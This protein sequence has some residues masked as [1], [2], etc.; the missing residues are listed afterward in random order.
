[1]QQSSVQGVESRRAMALHTLKVMSVHS[2]IDT[3]L[4]ET[5]CLGHLRRNL[6]QERLKEEKSVEIERSNELLLERMRLIMKSKGDFSCYE[7]K[8]RA[9]SLNFRVRKARELEIQ[10]E[11][12]AIV[13]R[14]CASKST[15]A[16][17]DLL[18][19]HFK[20][21]F[22]PRLDLNRVGK[23]DD[24][25]TVLTER[26]SSRGTRQW[27]SLTDRSL[28]KGGKPPRRPPGESASKSARR[29]P[30][31]LLIAAAAA[32]NKEVLLSS[33]S[34]KKKQK[35]VVLVRE[36]LKYRGKYVVASV[37]EARVRNNKLWTVEFYVP[38]DAR[39]CA[40]NIAIDD[41][42]KWLG[43]DL[44]CLLPQ[45]TTRTQQHA[46]ER[47]LYLQALLRCYDLVANDDNAHY[48]LVLVHEAQEVFAM[49]R[50]V[51]MKAA[52][53]KFAGALASKAV[54][55]VTANKTKMNEDEKCQKK[56]ERL[57][58]ALRKLN[59]ACLVRYARATQDHLEGLIS[60]A[61][62]RRVLR[63]EGQLANSDLSDNDVASILNDVFAPKKETKDFFFNIADL[64]N[65]SSS[66]DDKKILSP[67]VEEETVTSDL[68]AVTSP[69]NS[70]PR[71]RMLHLSSSPRK[72]TAEATTGP[73]SPRK[74]SNDEGA[75][76]RVPPSKVVAPKAVPTLR[77]PTRPS[78]A[79][80]R[81]R[82]EPAVA[83]KLRV[84]VRRTWP[85]AADSSRE[86]AFLLDVR[87]DGLLSRNDF[88]KI[89][90]NVCKAEASLLT[91]AEIENIL[92]YFD[93]AKSG[94]VRVADIADFVV[95]AQ[96]HQDDSL[97]CITECT[98][99]ESPPRAEAPP[100]QASCLDHQERKHV[101]AEAP[102]PPFESPAPA[103]DDETW[104]L[105][106]R[107]T[108]E[109]DALPEGQRL[110]LVSVR[111][112]PQEPLQIHVTAVRPFLSL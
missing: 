20:S 3:R 54:C 70:P 52:L 94:R 41:A 39:T 19:S 16:K 4:P 102:P 81:R 101:V 6:K 24:A 85:G 89:I 86:L 92:R 14:L 2:E 51:A 36:A 83:E 43:I 79:S 71:R 31:T 22:L 108:L 62:L 97:S 57:M 103:P 107:R 10:A 72:K 73:R 77:V 90:R 106:A 58:A 33:S 27:G 59:E 95:A 29:P 82:L 37:K 46:K 64:L 78:V 84:L 80:P 76:Y 55:A 87:G 17:A 5:M 63:K 35:M 9:C 99:L 98:A 47:H 60:L 1:M 110:G 21:H 104:P 18:P 53:A 96:Q 69:P 38:E 100:Q 66:D 67:V 91:D 49:M 12:K 23:N 30:R 111:L 26:K 11:N 32:T 93:A 48:E 65:W 61:S 75:P 112:R 28:K 13:K 40:S 109:F 45:L 44:K 25:F 8:R 68:T 88:R 50:E 74:L 56:K 7:P 15:Y 34:P 42:A 105:K